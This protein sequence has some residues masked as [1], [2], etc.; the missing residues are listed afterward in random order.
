MNPRSAATKGL[1]KRSRNSSIFCL[2]ERFGIGSGGQLAPVNDVHR[3]LRPHDGDFG[4]GP[5]EVDVRPD[6]LRSHH[7]IRAAIG[8][9]RDHGDFRNGGFGIGVEQLRAVAD[10]A[11]ELLLGAGQKAGDVF[12]ASESGY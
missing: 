2:R 8:F 7:A 1:A 3:A 5:R 6:V 4:G 11:A 12:E 9:A 10:D